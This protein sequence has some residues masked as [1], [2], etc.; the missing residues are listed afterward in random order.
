MKNNLLRLS[1][2][3]LT[4]ST[5]KDHVADTRAGNMTQIRP[6]DQEKVHIIKIPVEIKETMTKKIVFQVQEN[7]IHVV[8]RTTP[9]SVWYTAKTDPLV[10]TATLEDRT[11]KI[12]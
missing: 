3:A 1:N 11:T 4:V 10:M 12:S 7:T 6:V 5:T 9:V 2:S 8:E